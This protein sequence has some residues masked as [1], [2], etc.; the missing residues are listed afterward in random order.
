MMYQVLFFCVAV[1]VY[2]LGWEPKYGEVAI[3]MSFII[4]GI[5]VLGYVF[6]VV[7]DDNAVS[8]FKRK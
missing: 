3:E 5:T 8:V 1:I 6:G 7:L 2:S 4:I